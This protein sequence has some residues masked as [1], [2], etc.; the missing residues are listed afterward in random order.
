LATASELTADDVV[1]R[2]RTR[3]PQVRL[4]ERPEL[5]KALAAAEVAVTW[6]NTS[7]KFVR[8]ETAVGDLTTF[9]SLVRRDSTRIVTPSS[10]QALPTAEIDPA[11]TAAIELEG[12]LDRS[13]RSGGFLA[14]RVPT[15]RRAELQRELARFTGDPHHMTTV[16]IEAWFLDE[17]RAVAANKRVAWEKL[18]TA[19]RAAEGTTDHTNLRIL[20]REAAGRVE[21]RLAHAGQLVLAWNPGVLARYGELDT[22]DRLR[23]A[24]GRV[25]SGLRTLWLVVFGSMADAKPTIDGQPVPVIGRSEWVDV[26][27][28]WLANA[29]RGRA[30]TG[31]DSNFGTRTS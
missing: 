27:D 11:V 10:R 23:D 16:D 29:H 12:R 31:T 18:V 13:L 8:I 24:A 19:D 1:T 7:Q 30:A 15:T 9:T 17:L 6:S 20:T 28:S 21:D 5:D 4:P 22:I 26:T 14:L 25:D 3:F 2:V